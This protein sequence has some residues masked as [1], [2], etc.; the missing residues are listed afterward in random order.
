MCL[1]CEISRRALLAGGAV[2]A[3][4]LTT[5]VAE[6]RIRP[7]DMVPLVGPGFKPTDRD[8]QGLWKE[9]ERADEESAVP[10]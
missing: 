5:G 3:A 1:R 8:E 7:R 2:T 4:S 10:Q 9:M 6:A